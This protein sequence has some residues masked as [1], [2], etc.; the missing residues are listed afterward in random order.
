MIPSTHGVP[1]RS[2]PPSK[3]S[4]IVA[5]GHQPKKSLTRRP[6]RVPKEQGVSQ[7]VYEAWT[8]YLSDT[9]DRVKKTSFCG[10]RVTTRLSE[11]EPFVSCTNNSYGQEDL[12]TMHVDAIKRYQTT[13]KR[14]LPARLVRGRPKSYEAHVDERCQGLP[15]AV[16]AE[17]DFLLADREAASS[18]RFH[19]RDWTV[20]VVQEEY[21]FKFASPRYEEVKKKPGR[22]WK[23]NADKGPRQYFFVVCGR[24]GR[25][26]TDDKGICR[27]RRN[28]NPWKHVD[29]VE[30]RQKQRARDLRRYGKYYVSDF[31]ERRVR[32]SSPSPSRSRAR[33]VSPLPPPRRVHLG[34]DCVGAY[35]APNPFCPGIGQYNSHRVH[36]EYAMPPLPAQAPGPFMYGAPPPGAPLYFPSPRGPFN[37]PPP[38]PMTSYPD[39]AMRFAPPP[40]PPPPFAPVPTNLTG[41]SYDLAGW[42]D[43]PSPPTSPPSATERRDPTLSYIMHTLPDLMDVTPTTNPVAVRE[44][45]RRHMGHEPLLVTC[46]Y[47]RDEIVRRNGVD[48][49]TPGFFPIGPQ[50]SGSSRRSCSPPPAPRLS[51]LT[52]PTTFSPASS[53]RTGSSIDQTEVATPVDGDAVGVAPGLWDREG[54]VYS[55]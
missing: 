44:T 45:I 34:R 10:L 25:V 26:A 21:H 46:A 47:L 42:F 24:E 48:S 49:A 39:G 17:L 18:N 31:D 38:F 15:R 35:S 33:S 27:A 54:S 5:L 36:H 19:R 8:L 32:S 20:A 37:M 1:K 41:P 52:T 43:A 6:S 2:C 51:N 12:F 16:Q 30:R 53:D 4:L 13:T 3:R 50:Y 22:F 7:P 29:E 9:H 23:K 28:G 55:L 11:D 14:S 40:P